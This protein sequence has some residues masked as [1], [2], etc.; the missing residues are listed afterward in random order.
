LT[1]AIAFPV[2]L[3]GVLV[4]PEP[5]IYA[6]LGAGLGFIGFFVSRRRRAG[7]APA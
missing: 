1:T 4:V 7:R 6:M 5:E 2:T 3:I